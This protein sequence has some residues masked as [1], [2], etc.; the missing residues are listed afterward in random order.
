MDPA[1][2]ERIIYISTRIMHRLS[3][4]EK[5]DFNILVLFLGVMGSI[6]K[7]YLL[8]GGLKKYLHKMIKVER[9]WEIISR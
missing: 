5:L 7:N 1:G 6:K 9:G 2:G 8:L 4:E 3:Q